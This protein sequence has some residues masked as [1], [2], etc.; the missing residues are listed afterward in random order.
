MHYSYH[1]SA[2]ASSL[3][4]HENGIIRSAMTP[5]G[6]T[7]EMSC[8]YINSDTSSSNSDQTKTDGSDT[9]EIFN[10]K[11]SKENAHY[12]VIK[13]SP[14]ESDA[15]GTTDT[16]NENPMY[17]TLEHAAFCSEGNCQKE[18]CQTLKQFFIHYNSCN[19]NSSGGCTICF[20]LDAIVCQ[21]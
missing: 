20:A 16:S 7:P 3:Q 21:V 2:V 8:L 10:C 15:C 9:K 17:M 1:F 13:S 19:K 12:I 18:N 5:R 14:T 6:V 11:T 4:K